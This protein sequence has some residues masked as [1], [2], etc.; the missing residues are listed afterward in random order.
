M[1]DILA[2]MVMFRGEG[3]LN[4]Y[5]EIT[6]E[7]HRAYEALRAP[8]SGLIELKD[9]FGTRA[10]VDRGEVRAVILQ[11]VNQHTK[12]AIEVQL[13]NAR[14][15][16]TLQQRHASDPTLRFIGT[17]AGGMPNGSLRA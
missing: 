9:N 14:A 17:A 8:E 6:D 10:S 7:A 2:V 16:A 11:N 12:A 1:S 3:S 4:L 13:V 15:T 5:Y